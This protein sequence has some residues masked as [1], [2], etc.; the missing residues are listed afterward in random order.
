MSPIQLKNASY[1]IHTIALE[2]RIIRI[3][4]LHQRWGRRWLC[5]SRE[6]TR[7]GLLDLESNQN[8]RMEIDVLLVLANREASIS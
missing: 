7:L 8:K 2:L 6:R 5:P 4:A 1:V 3:G